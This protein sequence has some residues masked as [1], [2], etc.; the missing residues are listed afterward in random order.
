MSHRI[1]LPVKGC[2]TEIKRNV[3]TYKQKQRH[4]RPYHP[5]VAVKHL[6]DYPE[7]IPY[8]Y[9]KHKTKAFTLR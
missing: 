1:T 6:M 5:V 7:Y 8:F 4:I 3:H 2:I 9:K